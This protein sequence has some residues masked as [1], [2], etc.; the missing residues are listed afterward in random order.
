MTREELNQCK[1]QEIINEQRR[2]KRKK[3]TLF[4]F[5]MSCLLILGFL[6]FYLYTTYISTGRLIVKEERV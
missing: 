3:V 1:Q 2:E 6:L 4:V 5:K